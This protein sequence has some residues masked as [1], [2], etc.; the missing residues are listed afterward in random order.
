MR[1]RAA[2]ALGRLGDSRAIEPLL[3]ALADQDGDV[4]WD[5]IQ[6]LGE[7]GDPWAVEALTTA[8][9]DSDEGVRR[10]AREALDTRSGAPDLP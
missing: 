1:S 3:A 7:I 6:A 8:L 5:V 10:A 9:G 2:G 4:R